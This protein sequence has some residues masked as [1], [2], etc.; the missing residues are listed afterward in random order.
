MS[1]GNA[2]NG[3][4]QHILAGLMFLHPELARYTAA[5]LMAA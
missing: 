2:A 1:I 3:T 5:E 4:N